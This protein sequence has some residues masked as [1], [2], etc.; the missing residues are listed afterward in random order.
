ML[1]TL[2]Q[3]AVWLNI[4]ALIAAIGAA[5]GLD[6]GLD[7]QSQ[8]E[9]AV[10]LAGLVAVVNAAIH[11]VQRS[12]E[13]KAGGSGSGSGSINTSMLILPL[14]FALCLGFAGCAGTLQ[15]PHTVNDTVAYGGSTLQ[16]VQD[17]AAAQYAYMT[18]A[19]VTQVH[20]LIS[21][22]KAAREA[23]LAAKDA[24]N[25]DTAQSKMQTLS[26]LIAQIQAALPGNRHE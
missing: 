10:G 17:T 19:Q 26:N 7:A 3:K 8:T 11:G 14:I 12:R 9:I 4:L 13:K 6:L 23:M 21:K 1:Q 2:S 16:G 18:D 24:G 5:F 15:S 22:A 20:A 25:Y